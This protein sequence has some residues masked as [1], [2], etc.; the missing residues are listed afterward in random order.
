MQEK[1]NKI[2]AKKKRLADEKSKV[3]TSRLAQE[4]KVNEARTEA[5]KQ[6]EAEAALAAAA[7][8]E[9]EAPAEDAAP[10]EGETPAEA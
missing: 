2:D 7:P 1:A 5:R 3:L 8:A 6:K 10:A 4:V 9:S